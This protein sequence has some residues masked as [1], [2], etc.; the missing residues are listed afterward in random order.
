MVLRSK[1]QVKDGLQIEKVR[2]FVGAA[3]AALAE[4]RTMATTREAFADIVAEKIVLWRNTVNRATRLATKAVLSTERRQRK[5]RVM[6][7]E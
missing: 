6:S 4:W 7:D 5:L 3:A 1:C 2:F